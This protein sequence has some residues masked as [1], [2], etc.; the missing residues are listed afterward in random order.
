MRILAIGLLASLAMAGAAHAEGAPVGVWYLG[1]SSNTPSGYGGVLASLPGATLGRGFALRATGNGGEYDY[2]AG[3]GKVTAHYVGGDL[4]LV[5]QSSG[6]WGWGNVSAGPQYTHTS[7]S[8]RDPSN[9]RLGGHWE[10]SLQSDG[11]LYFDAWRVGWYGQGGLS[12]GSYDGRVHV[13]RRL[14]SEMFRLGAEAGVQG[15]PT[16]RLEK[17][18]P[19]L[20]IQAPNALTVQIG[21]GVRIQQNIPAQGFVSLGFSRVF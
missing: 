15:D 19:T 13:S 8:P 12:Q 21:A 10:A 4:A 6:A 2:S 20:Q 17:V 16:Y 11:E 14:G 9:K 5:Y 18:G 1:G 3:V 7:L